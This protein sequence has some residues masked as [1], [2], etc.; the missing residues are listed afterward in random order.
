MK[1]STQPK[2]VRGYRI[3]IFRGAGQQPPSLTTSIMWRES[4]QVSEWQRVMNDPATRQSWMIRS[5]R[6]MKYF[7]FHRDSG[8]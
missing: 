4:P 5:G 1:Q 7:Q 3:H 8:A 6:K 2:R